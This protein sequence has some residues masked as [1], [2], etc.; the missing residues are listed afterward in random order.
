MVAVLCSP[1]LCS[2]SVL[3]QTLHF[4]K[5]SHWFIGSIVGY[6][7]LFVWCCW[8][9]GSRCAT[10]SDRPTGCRSVT[11]IRRT[12]HCW[13]VVHRREFFGNCCTWY[14]LFIIRKERERERERGTQNG[15]QVHCIVYVCMCV[16]RTGSV[17][18]IVSCDQYT[19]CTS[20]ITGDIYTQRTDHRNRL[21][22]MASSEASE[23]TFQTIL[24]YTICM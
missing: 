8:S 12:V 5:S 1:S 13:I 4:T 22:W 18:V 2:N 17:G 9:D 14:R 7:Y 3:N 23:Q 6:G 19:L 16:C 15:T 21:N 11:I 10:A 24:M 20:H